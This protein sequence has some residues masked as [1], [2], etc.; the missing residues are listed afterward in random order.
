MPVKDMTA[1][2]E[3]KPASQL[4][5]QDMHIKTLAA[6]RKFCENRNVSLRSEIEYI[7]D[8]YTI[9]PF[10]QKRINA[11]HEMARKTNES[12]SDPF[13][14]YRIDSESKTRLKLWCVQNDVTMQAALPTFMLER[15]EEVSKE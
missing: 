7:I 11:V 9:L 13:Y 1:K 12:N 6:F 5:V 4:F 3:K 10:D 2:K 8:H 15:M 14:V